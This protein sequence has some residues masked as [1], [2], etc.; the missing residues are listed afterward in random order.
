MSS[1]KYAWRLRKKMSIMSGDSPNSHQN[2]LF[3]FKEGRSSPTPT[4]SK[5]VG[6][7]S[8]EVVQASVLVEPH[9]DDDAGKDLNSPILN[10]GSGEDPE[11]TVQLDD[12]DFS[13]GKRRCDNA[14]R[15]DSPEKKKLNGEFDRLDGVWVPP[16]RPEEQQGR[17]RRRRRQLYGEV[18]VLH[19]AVLRVYNRVTP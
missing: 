4:T 11:Q 5:D 14:D 17:R 6:V 18:P 10:S 9:R 3:D 16:A 19:H 13:G 7:Q 12:L 1:E 2:D 15:K 8:G